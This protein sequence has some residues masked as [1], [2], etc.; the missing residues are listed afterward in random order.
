MDKEILKL[1]KESK[2]LDFEKLTRFS[3]DMMSLK[4]YFKNKNKSINLVVKD[5]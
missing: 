2:D 4:N 1:F 3:L 5:E